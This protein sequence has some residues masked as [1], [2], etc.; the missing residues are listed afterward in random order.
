M[1]V[2]ASL[3]AATA[4]TLG[5]LGA[6]ALKSELVTELFAVYSTA[7]QYHMFH[8]LGL[9]AVAM[10]ASLLPESIWVKISGWSML[11]GIGLFS[12]SLYTLSLSGI[13]WLGAITPMGGILLIA[14][15]IMLAVGALKAVSGNAPRCENHRF[16]RS[17]RK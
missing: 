7:V 14:S 16:S 3:N 12:G 4:V 6:H 2:L 17:S 11:A 10:A 9:F 15:W 1:I 8:A 13:R 5:A